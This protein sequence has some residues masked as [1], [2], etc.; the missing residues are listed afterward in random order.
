[1]PETSES[2][3]I[4]SPELL[5]KEMPLLTDEMI[6]KFIAYYGLLIDWNSRMNLTRI[7]EPGEVAQKHF[8]DSIL[9]A[10][11][12]PEGAKVVDVG[13]GAGFPGVPLLI[14]RPDIELVMVDSLAKRISFLS[15]VLTKLGLSAGLFHARAEDA[16][17]KP[18]LREQFD[19][20]LSR[21]VAPMNVLLELTVPFLKVGG[22]SLMY[23]AASANEELK[24]AGSALTVLGCS[25]Q[26]HSFT[27]EWGERSIVAALKTAKTAKKY[28]RK[29][30]TPEK[31]PL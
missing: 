7:T 28:P 9:G 19:I 14:V 5:L 3:M 20:A 30:G 31:S 13:T 16:A 2:T 11:F 23:K 21:A 12:I 26:T 29:A 24:A 27:V 15:E 10:Q 22:R 25:A 4:M 6:G 18:E 1:M 17:R 8:A